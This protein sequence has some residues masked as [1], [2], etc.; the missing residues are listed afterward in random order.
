MA[1]YCVVFTDQECGVSRCGWQWSATS[2][3]RH[4]V[5]CKRVW[6]VAQCFSCDWTKCM[7]FCF[8]KIKKWVNCQTQKVKSV[9]VFCQFRLLVSCFYFW[10]FTLL[11][12]QVTCP[13]PLCFSRQ[14]DCLPRPDCFHLFP[15]IVCIYGLHVPLSVPVHL[16]LCSREPAPC[17][18]HLKNCQRLFH[19][20]SRQVFCLFVIFSPCFC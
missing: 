5:C 10:N 14:S 3:S 20:L 9:T 13:F 19:A 17:H 7:S 2:C 18:H 1:E 16:V 11:S 12:F 4:S 8:A 15:I 6:V